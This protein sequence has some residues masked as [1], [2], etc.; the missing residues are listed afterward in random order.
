MANNSP[1]SRRPLILAAALDLDGTVIG[2]NE[3]I[4]PAVHEAIVRLAERIHVFIATGREPAD[5]LRY[6]NELGLTAPQLC[7]GGANIL[8]PVQGV[9]TWTAPLGPV[10]AEAVVTR[11]REMGSAFVATHAGGTARTF[12][13]V[14]DWDL[15]RVSALDLDE[16]TADAL[17]TEFRRN[18]NMYV[19]K[20]VLPYNGLWAVDFTLAGVDKASG[21]ARVGQTLGVNPANMVAVGDSY[22]DLPMLEACGFSVAMGNAP[23]E[24]KDAAEFVAPSVAEDGLSVAIK[25]YVLP[26]V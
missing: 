24:V 14:P 25:E 17:A 15:I 19:I 22:N 6:A 18:K 21:I 10:N 1:N 3:N 26:R 11:L 16:D 2:P 20:A 7:D 8:D 4:S 12:D 23:P 5:V 13:D 9:S